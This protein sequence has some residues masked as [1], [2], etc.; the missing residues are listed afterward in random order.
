MVE[1][2]NTTIEKIKKIVKFFET[3][4]TSSKYSA[5]TVFNDGPNKRKQITFGAFQTTEYGNLKHLITMYINAGGK[6]ASEFKPYVNKIGDLKRPTLAENTSFVTLLKASAKDEIMQK[7]QE[8]FFETYYMNPAKKWFASNGFTLPL[9]LLVIFDSFIHSGGI[10]DFLRKRFAELPPIKGGDEKK[11]IEQYVWARD[12]WL[13]TNKVNLILRNTDYRTDSFILAIR[14]NNW[15]LDKPFKV[16]N[17]T[18][19]KATDTPIVKTI[20]V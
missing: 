18:T 3:S 17:Y 20:I 2:N 7:T 5:Y 10:L 13:E 11:W 6:L 8:L 14:E 12:N 15:M 1:I 9:S 19:E 4:S 16:V